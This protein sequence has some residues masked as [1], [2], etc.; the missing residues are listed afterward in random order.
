MT[1][2]W[3]E[4]VR[5]DRPGNDIFKGGIFHSPINNSLGANKFPSSFVLPQQE[6]SYNPNSPKN[7]TVTSKRFWDN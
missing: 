4:T 1:E 3:L 7:V 2:G 5:F 6:I